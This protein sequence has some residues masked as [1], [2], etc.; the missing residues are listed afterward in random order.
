MQSKSQCGCDAGALSWLRAHGVQR[1]KFYIALLVAL[2]IAASTVAQEKSLQGT[3]MFLHVWKCGGT[4]LRRLLC[5]WAHR[6]GLPCATVA[7]C[8]YP[9]LE[10]GGKYVVDE[11]SDFLLLY[12]CLQQSYFCAPALVWIN[13]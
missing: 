12:A 9:E 11:R 1:P 8:R 3:L 7:G 6:E 13:F 2:L 10:V 5:E 4:S